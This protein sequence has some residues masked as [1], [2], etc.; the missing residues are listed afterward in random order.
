[1]SRNDT[2]IPRLKFDQLDLSRGSAGES[3]QFGPQADQ[4][5]GVICSLEDR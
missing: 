5:M 3:Q 1:M 2:D 4:A